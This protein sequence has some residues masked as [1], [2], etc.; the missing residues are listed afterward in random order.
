MAWRWQL[1]HCASWS[2]SAA[3]VRVPRT[4]RERLFP[5]HLHETVRQALA[6]VVGRAPLMVVLVAGPN[7]DTPEA[8][9]TEGLET[10]AP[11]TEGPETRGLETRGLETQVPVTEGR[12]TAGR[13]THDPYRGTRDRGLYRPRPACRQALRRSRS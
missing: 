1:P 4:R 6:Q 13:E 12:E 11:E 10:A 9:A 2:A 5:L 3:S 8:P 7:E